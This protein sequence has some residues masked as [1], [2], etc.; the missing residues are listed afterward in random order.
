[1]KSKK[2]VIALSIIFFSIYSCSSDD[3]QEINIPELEESTL[4]ILGGGGPGIIGFLI[5]SGEVMVNPANG[6]EILGD[7]ADGLL[8]FAVNEQ[9]D[10]FRGTYQHAENCLEFDCEVE[11]LENLSFSGF[12]YSNATDLM[13]IADNF[14]AAIDGSFEVDFN[15][16]TQEFTLDYVLIT[17]NGTISG[18]YQGGFEILTDGS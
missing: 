6:E 4:F 10:F 3:S 5:S 17:A 12:S 13:S 8:I 1:M 14:A 16:Q 2:I 11:E 18:T 7:L 9:D 15:E